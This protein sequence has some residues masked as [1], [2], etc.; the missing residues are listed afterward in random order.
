MLSQCRGVAPTRIHGPAFIRSYLEFL[1]PFADSEFGEVKYPGTVIEQPWDSG[2][3]K[4]VTFTINYIP[5]QHFQSGANTF[6][7]VS[8]LDE[9]ESI[10]Y[11]IETNVRF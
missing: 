9:R 5:M 1:R 8:N 2:P 3:Y 7:P 11:L 6:E 10:A 4:D